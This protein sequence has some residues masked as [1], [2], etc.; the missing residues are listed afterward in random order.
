[1]AR[2]MFSRAVTGGLDPLIFVPY[3][4]AREGPMSS[5]A[6]P[7]PRS[8]TEI[9]DASVQ[10]VRHHFGPL[11]V[12]VAI[13]SA[14]VWIARAVSP[15]A[16]AVAL[17]RAPTGQPQLGE[18]SWTWAT[19]VWSQ[20][21]TTVGL[22]LAASDLYLGHPVAVASTL[23]KTIRR[24][25][26]VL[27][28]FITAVA[29]ALLVAAACAVP[30][31]AIQLAFHQAPASAFMYAPPLG[32]AI[33]TLASLTF[34][35]A[36]LFASLPIVVIERKSPLAAV[37]RSWSLTNGLHRH[38]LATLG[39]VYVV[40]VAP[41]FLTV[42]ILSRVHHPTLI[43][44]TSTAIAAVIAPFGRTAITFLYYD[45]RVRKEGYDIELMAQP[46]DP[47]AIPQVA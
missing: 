19:I 36:R 17:L 10:L 16:A 32:W 31:A 41:Y 39:L 34:M 6:V 3:P 24:V 40:F 45:L 15:Q 47:A 29:G 44:A 1:M 42:T 43:A 12:L 23:I 33:A 20:L 9:L 28:L 25:P 2:T 7:R 22:S 37:H 14:P 38:T 21:T 8:A 11:I 46:I 27:M 18:V 13:C 4:I 35:Y 30:F 5:V 26:A